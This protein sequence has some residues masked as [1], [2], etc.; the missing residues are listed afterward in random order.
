M[1]TGFPKEG[2]PGSR[3]GYRTGVTKKARADE[4]KDKAAIRKAILGEGINP[5]IQPG[6]PRHRVAWN[7][8]PATLAVDVWREY[9]AKFTLDELFTPDQ[10]VPSQPVQPPQPTEEEIDLL[11]QPLQVGAGRERMQEGLT[12]MLREINKSMDKMIKWLERKDQDNKNQ[13]STPVPPVVQAPA[14]SE[15]QKKT[16]LQVINEMIKAR[17]TQAEVDFMDDHGVRGDGTVPSTEFRLLQERGLRVRDA[18]VIGLRLNPQI[19]ETIIKRWSATWLNNARAEKDQIDRKKSIIES[20]GQEEAIRQYAEWLGNDLVKK[21]PIG[22]KETLK[23]LLMST[24]T[25]LFRK[26]QL[27]KLMPEGQEDLEEIIKWIEADGS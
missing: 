13:K 1:D 12:I 19:E 6:S 2:Q 4:L 22:V 8:L 25:I 10:L 7:Q 23:T 11:S 9:V 5:N 24:R 17:L 18:A 15:L 27:R 14:K 16:A 21:K 3:F 20:A 26:D